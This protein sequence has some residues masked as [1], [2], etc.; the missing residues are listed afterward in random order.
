LISIVFL[1]GLPGDHDIYAQVSPFT[2]QRVSNDDNPS[3]TITINE[4]G[5]HAIKAGGKRLSLIFPLTQD[6]E[7]LLELEWFSTVAA[8]A[9]FIIGGP[10]GDEPI[11]IPEVILYRGRI[12]DDPGSHAFLA[13]T[14]QGSANGYLVRGNG[15]KYYMYHT[16]S[17][18]KS[19]EWRRFAITP[20]IPVRGTIFGDYEPTCAWDG[21]ISSI[22]P[23]SVTGRTVDILTAG[24]R[25]AKL[26]IEADE[27]YVHDVF[28]GDLTAASAYAIQLVG[29]TSD[30]YQRDLQMKLQI[31]QLRLWYAGCPFSAD[32]IEGMMEYWVMLEDTTGL[33]LIEL[34]S[35]RRDLWYYGLA[36]GYGACPGQGAF[37][38][39]A[40][41]NGSF[42]LPH[43]VPN[44]GNGDLFCVTHE[45]GHNFGT[46]HTH[47]GS[48]D[49]RIDSCGDGFYSRGTIMSYC[50]LFP[51][52]KA[53][54]DLYFH[55][56]VRD[57]LQLGFDLYDCYAYDCNGNDIADSIDIAGGGSF[58]MNGNGVPDECED[59]NDNGILDDIDIA[60]GESDINEN[61]IPDICE[62]DCNENGFPDNYD[63]LF[64]SEDMNGNGIPDECEPDCNQNG[65]SDLVEVRDGIIDDFDRNAIPDICQDC[66][67]NGVTDWIDVGRQ[68]NIFISDAEEGVIREFLWASGVQVG[69]IEDALIGIPT[70]MTFGP[71]RQLY[72]A[73]QGSNSVLKV[74]VDSREVSHFVSPESGGLEQPSDLVFMPDGDLLVADFGTGTIKE[75]DGITGQYT[76][77]FVDSA[78]GN[79]SAPTDLTFGPFGNLYVATGD[80]RILKFSGTDGS[81][82]EEFV[83]P[84]GGELDFGQGM[85]FKPDGNLVI[86]SINNNLV[87]EFDGTDGS[88][89][90]LFPGVR[91]FHGLRD[92]CFAPNGNVLILDAVRTLHLQEYE[93]ESDGGGRIFVNRIRL[94]AS[95]LHEG[96]WGVALRPASPNDCNS[97]NI[98]DICD[99]AD[100][101]LSDGNY[102]GFPDE[103]ESNDYDNDGIYDFED[104]CLVNYNP[105]QDDSD[106]DNVGDVCDRCPGHDDL[107]DYDYDIIPDDCD[108]CMLA[109]NPHQSDTDGDLIGDSCDNCIHVPGTDQTDSDS[110]GVGDI[111]DIC[112]GF[113]DLVDSDGDSIPDGC[114]ICEGFDDNLD[115]D[116]D[117]VPDS[118]D[119]CDG[120]DDLADYDEDS[121][122][123]SCDNC[124]EMANPDQDDLDGDGIGDICD[125]YDCG[126]ANSDK[127]INVGDAVFLI[128]YVFKGGPAPDPL[129]AGDANCDSDINVGDAVYLINYVFKGGPEPCCP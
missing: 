129:E 9:R 31:E 48:Y 65:V 8:D 35:G 5:Y 83:G 10:A 22:S 117:T 42:Y 34:L 121:V 96:A 62:P 100:G 111:C 81:F 51:G 95:D 71:D 102:N 76:G 116:S 120:F 21:E 11:D 39:Q 80:N 91:H 57:H 98:P 119:K 107:A 1:A 52:E 20:E 41:M 30:I 87:L 18:I 60:G 25:I 74:D 86:A 112:P 32:D 82:V 90:R 27:A 66:N 77:E 19:K 46:S 115:A 101:I 113:D 40:Y 84:Q 43:D 2:I 108:N 110:D 68:H 78:S 50:H 26:A 47:D 4:Y 99:I 24:P 93:Y 28:G 7:V 104:N 69:T 3:I 79:L 127:Q 58:D 54:I 36:T 70:Q 49:P 126:D 63:L 67:T 12:I 124:P 16:A 38:I 75:Y 92:I 89:L 97:N 14:E 55:S 53:N 6:E 45:W 15:Q 29:V 122:P 105:S 13:F 88:Y 128:S 109:Y 37:G 123:D 94:N 33:N 59:C 106:G 64:S 44:I 118:C 125:I 103:C 23:I 85:I 72:V 114:D 73:D 56:R 61:G 17:Q